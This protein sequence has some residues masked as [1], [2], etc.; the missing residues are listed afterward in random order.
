MARKKTSKTKKVLNWKPV[1]LDLD[2]AGQGEFEGLVGFEELDC[3]ELVKDSKGGAVIVG[4]D[5][6]ASA[7]PKVKKNEKRNKN[8]SFKKFGVKRMSRVSENKHQT[9]AAN[10]KEVKKKGLKRKLDGTVVTE[11]KKKTETSNENKGVELVNLQERDMSA[12][13]NLFVPNSVLKAL[14]AM[15]FTSPTPIQVLSLPP[16]IRDRRD[17]IGAAETGSGKTLAFGIPIVHRILEEKDYIKRNQTENNKDL[18]ACPLRALVLTPT[19]ELAIQVKKHLEA[20][21][22]FTD[23]KVTVVVGGMAPQKQQRLLKKCPEIVVATP[24]RLWELIEEGEPHLN[25]V[26]NIKYLVI[27]EADR[28]VEKGH[29]LELKQLLQLINRDEEMRKKRQTFVFS[30]TLTMIHDLPQRLLLNKRKYKL[31]QKEK[32]E[33][34][35]SEL[36][37]RDKPKIIDLSRRVGTVE[38]LTEAC[39]NCSL[40]EKDLYLYYFLLTYPGRT[41]VFCNSI[42][43]VRRLKNVLDLLAC[44]PLPLHASMHQRQRLKNLDK[45]TTSERGLLLA[46]DVAARGLDI[47]GV[48]HVVHYQVPRTAEIYV[49]RSGRTARAQRE[50]LSLM[51]VEPQEVTFYRKLC[52]TLNRDEDL[53]LFPVDRAVLIMVRERVNLAKQLDVLEHRH[54]QRLAQNNWIKK[55][56]GEMDLDVGDKED[57]F[58]HD[59][60]DPTEQSGNI[61]QIKVMKKSLLTM[62]NQPVVRRGTGGSYPTKSGK[63]TLPYVQSQKKAVTVVQGDVAENKRFKPMGRR[64]KLYKKNTCKGHH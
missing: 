25:Q 19:R 63:L 5:K 59:M 40:K 35:M 36:G 1:T 11:T 17:I 50:G 61:K 7:K 9:D 37:T 29:F 39:I 15:N 49:H 18:P 27:D 33:L 60:Q 6:H 34:L 12:W 23:L 3:Y 43:C 52:K 30:A 48:E 42:D 51:L 26:S 24:G 16:A 44:S 55:V 64:K 22:R 58:L 53:P 47:P 45:F 31:T 56:A 57:N 2:L 20:I 4:N 41:L 62:L 46:T 54:R 28:M 21:M 8:G 32:L 14:G 38:T 13:T 10:H